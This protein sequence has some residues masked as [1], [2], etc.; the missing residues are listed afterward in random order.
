MSITTLAIVIKQ[1]TLVAPNVFSV[2]AAIT[3]AQFL[4]VYLL[5]GTWKQTK[6]TLALLEKN[7][8]R[9]GVSS[10]CKSASLIRL[11]EQSTPDA[12]GR[13]CSTHPFSKLTWV[14]RSIRPA[15]M[16]DTMRTIGERKG[17]L[18]YNWWRTKAVES[19]P[20]RQLM[21][22]FLG[23]AFKGRTRTYARNLMKNQR[24]REHFFCVW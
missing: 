18:N 4:S 15:P 24:K 21:V 2:P 14:T 23:N 3:C 5:C 19:T 8:G 10:L 6:K 22:G 16:S 17:D 11:R 9:D 1:L 7:I 20:N 12:V 13:C